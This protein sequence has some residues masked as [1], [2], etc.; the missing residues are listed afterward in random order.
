M[1]GWKAVALFVIIFVFAVTA[2]YF[3]LQSIQEGW[4]VIQQQKN[5]E[6]KTRNISSAMVATRGMETIARRIF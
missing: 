3:G 6:R 4:E 1:K 2:G 5:S